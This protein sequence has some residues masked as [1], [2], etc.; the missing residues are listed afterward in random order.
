[1]KK[2][3]KKKIRSQKTH[4]RTHSFRMKYDMK[5]KSMNMRNGK[6][7][8]SYPMHLCKRVSSN[9]MHG[10]IHAHTQVH[11]YSSTIDRQAIFIFYFEPYDMKQQRWRREKKKQ[12][13]S[14]THTH[15]LTY[16]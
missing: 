16:N 10:Y 5:T 15:S 11:D 6:A 9:R 12:T 1:M 7:M 4:T 13:K 8:N 14:N 2:K 3:Q